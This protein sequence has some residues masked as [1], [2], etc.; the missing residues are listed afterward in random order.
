MPYTINARENEVVIT[1]SGIT[2]AEVQA[3]L[4]ARQAL[5]QALRWL[6]N[7][8]SGPGVGPFRVTLHRALT[9]GDQTALEQAMA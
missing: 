1:F 9:T 4:A 2:L 8:I 5:L 7:E 6:V 3:Y